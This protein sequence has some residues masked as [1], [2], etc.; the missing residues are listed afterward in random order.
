MHTR[1]QTKTSD[2]VGQLLQE[3]TEQ[4]VP[5]G[6]RLPTELELMERFAVSRTTVRLAL[7]ELTNRGLIERRQGLGTFR[8]APNGSRKPAERLMLVGVWFNLPSGPLYGPMAEG[9]RQELAHH[10]YHAVFEGGMG[11]GE[12]LKGVY[13]LIRKGLDGY[14]VSPSS[15]PRDPHE[16][17]LE[18]L[19]QGSPVVLV[20]KQVGQA[21]ADLVA[22]N[23]RLGAEVLTE[24]LID[25]GHRRIG[26]IGT[27]GVSTVEER[28]GGYEAAMRRRGLGVHP[29][30]VGV[31]ED[32]FPDYGR[33]AAIKML[34]LPAETRPTAVFGVNDPIAETAAGA[35][36]SLGLVVPRDLS[37]VGFDD[38]G[39]DP[40]QPPWLTTYAQP[41]FRIGQQAAQLLVRR[42]RE[43]AGRRES[44]LLEGTLMVRE[45]TAPPANG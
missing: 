9:I 37:V 2:I 23:G 34:G 5:V 21:E 15:N 35:A 17:I 26:F 38:A 42:I 11:A 1:R 20:D 24:H 18:M 25:L 43:P 13:S 36:R 45:S 32:V 7:A 28:L 12:Q 30:W 41:K 19:R 44:V 10:D 4:R 33:A 8:A 16:P 22:T 3:L 27:A 29:A 14:I 6:Q 39:F 31:S 40:D